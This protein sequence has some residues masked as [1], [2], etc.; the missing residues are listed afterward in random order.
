MTP[1]RSK[2]GTSAIA[3]VCGTARNASEA[4]EAIAS[5]SGAVNDEVC[6]TCQRRVDLSEC[7]ALVG[8]R[9]SSH[10]THLRDGRAPDERPLSPHSPQHLRPQR[11]SSRTPLASVSACEWELY[12]RIVIRVK[13][14]AFFAITSSVA[15]TEP[16]LVQCARAGQ[17]PVEGEGMAADGRHRYR[18]EPSAVGAVRPVVPHQ[19]HVAFGHDQGQFDASGSDGWPWV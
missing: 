1:R 2:P 10:E 5:A 11:R 18:T 13:F 9:R 12:A 15:F 6:G 4:W 14:Y 19:P 3:A 16:S 8:G 7:A 17:R